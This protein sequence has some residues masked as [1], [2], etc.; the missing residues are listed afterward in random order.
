MKH[1]IHIS[2]EH[3]NYVYTW[4]VYNNVVHNWGQLNFEGSPQPPVLAQLFGSLTQL[5]Y[6]DRQATASLHVPA[7]FVDLSASFSGVCSVLIPFYSAEKSFSKLKRI[8]HY[9]RK[10]MN[11]QRLIVN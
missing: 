3:M 5:S 8:K 9:P 10:S 11:Q 7:K 4:G 1:E 2:D 6:G